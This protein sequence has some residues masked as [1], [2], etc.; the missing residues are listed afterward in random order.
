M[1][2]QRR[3][4]MTLEHVIREIEILGIPDST[5][6][7]LSGIST[8]TFSKFRNRLLIPNHGTML[9][10]EG[11]LAQLKK[12]SEQVHPLPLNF[13]KVGVLR[14]ILAEMAEGKVIIIVMRQEERTP[15][16]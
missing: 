11:A 12:L 6:S 2:M 4:V 5:L 3:N 14:D 8:G 15:I 9:R 13:T 1:F 10:I 16:G 7:A